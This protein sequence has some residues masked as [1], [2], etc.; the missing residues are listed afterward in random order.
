MAASIP[1]P[2]DEVVVEQVAETQESPSMIGHQITEAD[3]E[4]AGLLC[5]AECK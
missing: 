4:L 3:A 2:T 1:D 5:N